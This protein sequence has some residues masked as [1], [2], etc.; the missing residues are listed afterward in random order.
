MFEITPEILAILVATG[1]CAGFVDSIA[2]GGGNI[3][4]KG[5]SERYLTTKSVGHHVRTG[6]PVV[7]EGCEV[8]A[9]SE[10]QKAKVIRPIIGIAVFRLNMAI[11]LSLS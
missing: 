1:F 11:S 9:P 8:Y 5:A 4:V 10:L 6:K 2:G 3:R 7:Y